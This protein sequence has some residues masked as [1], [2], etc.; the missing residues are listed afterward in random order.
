M[1][2]YFWLTN[3]YFPMQPPPPTKK[4]ETNSDT[5]LLNVIILIAVYVLYIFG[6]TLWNLHY[7]G[8]ELWANSLQRNGQLQNDFYWQDTYVVNTACFNWKSM[9]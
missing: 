7:F 9:K 2:S 1:L 5:P 8:C 3:I 6:N 4:N